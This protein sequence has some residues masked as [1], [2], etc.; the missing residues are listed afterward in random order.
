MNFIKKQWSNILFGAFIVLMIV[1]QT[2]MPIQIFIQRFI[3]FSP[4]KID[5]EDRTLLKDYN[6]N[7]VE[8]NAEKVNLSQSKGKVILINFWA[9]WCPPCV[10]EMPELQELYDNYG[11]QV[12]F[13]FI[14]NEALEKPNLFLEKKGYT[15]PVFIQIEKSPEVLESSSLPTTY[16][17]SKSGEIVMRKTGAASWNNV[18][19]HSVLDDL[20]KE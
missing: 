11:D 2:R 6:W 14:T 8:L 13:Y 7:L 20:L 12:D 9:T 4:S 3:S 16:L 18:K 17:I 15:I 10:A 5:K 19:V 1:P